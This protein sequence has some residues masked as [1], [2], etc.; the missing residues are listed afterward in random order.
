[1]A[2]PEVFPFVRQK[3]ECLEEFMFLTKQTIEEEERGETISRT[4]LDEWYNPIGAIS[5]YDIQDG[6][7]F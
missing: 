2:H 7:G 6:C 5:L 1:M 3:T 4:I